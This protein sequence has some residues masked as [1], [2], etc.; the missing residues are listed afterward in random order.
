MER[1]VTVRAGVGAFVATI[2]LGLV[3]SFVIF[4][5][6]DEYLAQALAQSGADLS[7]AEAALVTGASDGVVLAGVI[8]GLILNA[9]YAL[10]V[11]FTWKGHNWARIVLWVLG[12]IF[13][14]FGLLGL[15]GQTLPFVSVMN[16]FTLLLTVAGIV[17]LALKPSN[18][19]FRFRSWQRATGHG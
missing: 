13:A 17:L 12:G 4:L 8:F 9:A 7:E 1:P 19:W 14:F 5:N 15:G 18:D 10:F 3:S 11:W 6:W 2:V 16:V